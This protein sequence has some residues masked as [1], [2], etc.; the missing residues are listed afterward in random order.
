MATP[1]EAL[2]KIRVGKIVARLRKTHGYAQRP[3]ARAIGCSQPHLAHME[4]GRAR[5]TPETRQKIADV[6]GL[7]RIDAHLE[8]GVPLERAS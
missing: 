7:D 5:V 2:E 1:E 4:T 6:L 3:F 8:L